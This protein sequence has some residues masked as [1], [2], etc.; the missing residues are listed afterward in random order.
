LT[1]THSNPRATKANGRWTL[2]EDAEPLPHDDG[3]IDC[4]TKAHARWT[5]DEDAEVLSA[6]AKTIKNKYGR[7]NR[8]DWFT[9]AAL[10]AGRKKLQCIARWE[11]VLKPTMVREAGRAGSWTPEEDAKLTSA[12]ANTR[13]TVWGEKR[14]ID[15]IEIALL[16]PGRTKQQCRKRYH[17]ALHPNIDRANIHTGK[18][19]AAEDS[20]LKRA[21]QTH[22]DKD[23][24]AISALIPS[25][26]KKQCSSRWDIMEN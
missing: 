22:G 3:K 11:K 18:W 8:I 10:L 14:R 25:R 15:W 12:V 1:D 20:K 2:E 5:P 24:A 13:K 16:V 4:S 9:V 7:Q 23:W 21:T 6:V 26:T 17:N 19:T